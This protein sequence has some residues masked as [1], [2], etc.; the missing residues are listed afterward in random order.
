MGFIPQRGSGAPGR[1]PISNRGQGFGR[2]RQNFS[3]RNHNN[4]SKVMKTSQ[5][6]R[7]NYPQ[8]NQREQ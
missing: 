4:Q 5:G 7:R 6:N 8:M 1:Y 3:R 2:G